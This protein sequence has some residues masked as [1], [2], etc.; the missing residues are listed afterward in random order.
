LA[1]GDLEV[2]RKTLHGCEAGL[3]DGLFSNPKIPI[4]GKVWRVLLWKILVYFMIIWS[5][6]LLLE[7]FYGHLVYFVV[8]WYIFPRFGILYQ[9]K[10]GNPEAKTESWSKSP[11]LILRAFIKGRV[12]SEKND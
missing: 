7:I 8:M 11:P 5:I 3:P 10:S 12:A 9:E 6:L 2:G 4:L 1:A